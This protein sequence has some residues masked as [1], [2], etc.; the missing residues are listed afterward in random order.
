MLQP[1]ADLDKVLQED[2]MLSAQASARSQPQ[3]RAKMLAVELSLLLLLRLHAKRSSMIS[4]QHEALQSLL[5]FDQQ[6]SRSAQYII[7]S[8]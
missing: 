4:C 7:V 1:R 3:H 5:D 2:C 6:Q 8:R